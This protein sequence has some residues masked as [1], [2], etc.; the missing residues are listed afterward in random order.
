[1]G[2]GLLVVAGGE[3]MSK[4]KKE[5]ISNIMET[6]A[7]QAKP[8]S[9][10]AAEAIKVWGM[11]VGYQCVTEFAGEGLKNTKARPQ[12]VP[13]IAE[14]LTHYDEKGEEIKMD[15]EFLHAI[16]DCC[17]DKDAK[18][19]SAVKAFFPLIMKHAGGKTVMKAI[20]EFKS[21]DQATL[22]KSLKKFL[23]SV[24]ADAPKKKKKDKKED[25]KKKKDP[26]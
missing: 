16:L 20:G 4:H 25:K 11:E 6:A 19:K 2:V 15:S 7:E 9:R 24:E 26:K 21:S 5:I 18:I 13:V 12:L 14:V 3:K 22:Q 10:A 8:V 17:I 1:M 23:A